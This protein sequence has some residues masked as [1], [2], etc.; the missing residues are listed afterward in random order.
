MTLCAVRVTV[1]IRPVQEVVMCCQSDCLYQ[2]GAG[3]R[4]V[5]SE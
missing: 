4:Y 3:G 2:T 5:L 1:C